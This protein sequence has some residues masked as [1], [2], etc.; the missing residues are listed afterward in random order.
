MLKMIIRM[1]IKS[2]SKRNIAWM[3]YTERLTVSLLK[4]VSRAW[5]IHQVLWCTGTAGIQKIMDGLGG[6]STP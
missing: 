5:R 1:T 2:I 6:L 3:G 4:W